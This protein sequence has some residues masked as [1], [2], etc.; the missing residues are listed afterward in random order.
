[1]AREMGVLVY[2]GREVGTSRYSTRGNYLLPTAYLPR[3]FQALCFPSSMV[4]KHSP[5]KFRMLA[6]LSH[7]AAF[8]LCILLPS[9]CIKTRISHRFRPTNYAARSE[10]PPPHQPRQRCLQTTLKL[11]H[12]YKL[13]HSGPFIIGLTFHREP[14]DA[15]RDTVNR[16]QETRY[17]PRFHVLALQEHLLTRRT[18]LLT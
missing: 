18:R 5:C 1:M 8:I 11:R 9:A 17:A 4:N 10:F 3:R 12:A 2:L 15:C 6:S 13:L 14:S 7:L 16:G